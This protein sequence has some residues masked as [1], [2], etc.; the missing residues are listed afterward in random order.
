MFETHDGRLHTIKL[1]WY[2]EA[3]KSG[4]FPVR[5][6]ETAN[7]R[8]GYPIFNF[9]YPL[10]FLLGTAPNLLGLSLVSSLKLVLVSTYLLSGILSYLFLREWFGRHASFAGAILYQFAPY[11]FVSLFVTGRWA[12][13]ISFAFIPLFFFH[14]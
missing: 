5:W 12:E 1:Y 10:L 11:R 2:I 6:T 13:S 3:L 9:Y 7:N 4:Q 8:Y 14:I